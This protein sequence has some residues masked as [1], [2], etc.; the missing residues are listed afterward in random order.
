[1]VTRARHREPSLIARRAARNFCCGA[2]RL[3]A[4]RACE[5]FDFR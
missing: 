5:A 2:H 1:M 3:R 4:L